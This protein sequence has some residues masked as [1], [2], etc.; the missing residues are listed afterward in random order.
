MEGEYDTN[1][2]NASDNIIDFIFLNT[3]NSFQ[4]ID[5]KTGELIWKTDIGG[6][7][8]E[9]YIT[10]SGKVYIA[11]R[12][13]NN[14]NNNETN[15]TYD[16]FLNL[17]SL[18]HETGISNWQISL[19]QNGQISKIYLN[20]DSAG[21]ITILTESGQIT[22]INK[23]DGSVNS[24]KELELSIVAEPIFQ[25]N[26]II[27]GTGDGRV[28]CISKKD[29][30]VITEIKISG[31][32]T[33]ILSSGERLFVGDKSGNIF[34]HD[35]KKKNVKWKSITGGEITSITKTPRGLV[36]SSFDNY[37][38][39]LSEKSGKRIW[40]KRLS[41]R[42]IGKPLIKENVAVF[43]TFGG[44]DTVFIDLDKGKQIN[45]VILQEENYF[46]NNPKSLGNLLVFSTLKGLIAQST[47][48]EC[49]ST[50]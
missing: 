31:A 38:Y 13:V 36:V 49:I 9:S 24:V 41:G 17:R 29:W 35:L 10:G 37:V 22:S 3:D 25:E 45:S 34:S 20:E 11:S 19:P 18:S 28:L 15:K 8:L 48:K 1:A 32:P 33:E 23:S 21:L 6:Q 40:R 16:Y 12:G 46:L 44:S 50:K 42:S 27:L 5:K 14:D 4:A 39:F 26:Q 47:T 2:L 30:S 43:S 7:F